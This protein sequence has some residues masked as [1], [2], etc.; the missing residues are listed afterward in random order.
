MIICKNSTDCM[1]KTQTPNIS[2]LLA[3]QKLVSHG[4]LYIFS[5]IHSIHETHRRHKNT[6][7]HQ[8]FLSKYH[9]LSQPGGLWRFYL[10]IFTVF[11][12]EIYNIY[13]PANAKNLGTP[14]FTC[15]IKKISS[16]FDPKLFATFFAS[17]T[18]TSYQ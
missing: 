7:C 18:Q 2:Y 15:H 13:S 5:H 12:N 9:T 14:F 8:E 1:V 6:S 11:H 16:P 17:L 4:L 3:M 10:T